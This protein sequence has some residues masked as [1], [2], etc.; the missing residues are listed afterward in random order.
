MKKETLM[1][2]AQKYMGQPLAVWCARYLYR[3]IVTKVGADFLTLSDPRAVEVS[4]RASAST[5]DTEDVI[6]S[7][8]TISAGAIEQF[9]Q[10]AWVWSG[11]EAKPPKK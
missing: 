7:D 8:L 3:G 1:E 6:P 2:Q 10:P 11:Y 4:G 5:P 9:C